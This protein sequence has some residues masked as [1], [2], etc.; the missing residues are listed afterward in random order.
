MP[1]LRRI[2]SLLLCLIVL[3]GVLASCSIDLPQETNE[4]EQPE[5]STSAPDES[6]SEPDEETTEPIEQHTHTPENA[7][8]E[9]LVDS[10]C[11]A[12]GS[13]DEVVYCTECREE[14]SRTK[15]TVEKKAHDYEMLSYT[16]YEHDVSCV[17]CGDNSKGTHVFAEGTY[18]CTVCSFSTE[19]NPPKFT[20]G[21]V[22]TEVICI[23]TEYAIYELGPGVYV[24]NDLVEKTDALCRALETVT[25]LSFENASY[26]GKKI[27]IGV[28]NSFADSDLNIS[29]F[30]VNGTAAYGDCVSYRGDECMHLIKINPENLFLGQSVTIAHELAHVLRYYQSN[31]FFN[32]LIEEGF[33]Q[34]ACESVLYY[35]DKND[36]SLAQSL[37]YWRE[38]GSGFSAD[39]IEWRLFTEDIAYFSPNFSWKSR[40]AAV[41]RS[42]RMFL[43][44]VSRAFSI[45]GRP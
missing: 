44:S 36:I 1:S 15:K 39:A 8:T 40:R 14:I 13:Y 2:I 5:E 12:E 20:T 38:G 30:P 31:Y 23:E 26:G 24:V 3:A 16:Y 33:A 34:I 37:W 17:N 22:T 41:R 10:S 45:W 9:N 18:T 43:S 32:T 21:F 19:G 28:Y 6:E 29:G 7:V 35:L 27:L 42:S 25:G 11:T 4:S